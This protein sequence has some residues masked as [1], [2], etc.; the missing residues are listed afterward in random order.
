MSFEEENRGFC[1]YYSS[2]IFRNSRGFE[3]GEYHSASIQSRDAFKPIVSER[4]I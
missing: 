4:N 1:V 2:N 3:N